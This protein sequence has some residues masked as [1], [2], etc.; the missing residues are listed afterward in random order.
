[1]FQNSICV[2]DKE[3]EIPGNFQPYWHAGCSLCPVSTRNVGFNYCYKT[4]PLVVEFLQ[5][6]CISSV[7]LESPGQW[8]PLKQSQCSLS[9]LS[10]RDTFW[11]RMQE[12]VGA[13]RKQQQPFGCWDYTN[14]WHTPQFWM[15][16]IKHVCAL[17]CCQEYESNPQDRCPFPSTASCK[18]LVLLLS[19]TLRE[20]LSLFFALLFRF[21]T[22]WFLNSSSKMTIKY[23]YLT[24]CIVSFK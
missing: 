22:R 2:E 11:H 5:L 23:Q 6:P 14:S 18:L 10:V 16:F 24:D 19:I 12:L 17:N 13:Q 21:K 1:M 9:S 15:V 4:W 20:A 7:V 8:N 3:K